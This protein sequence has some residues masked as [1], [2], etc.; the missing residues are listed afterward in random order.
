MK[1]KKNVRKELG[2]SKKDRFKRQFMIIFITSKM[3]GKSVI[4]Y[5]KE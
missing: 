1:K 2:I 5:I 3:K 4:V